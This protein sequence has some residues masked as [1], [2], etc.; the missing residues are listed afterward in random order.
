M[1]KYIVT[2]IAEE[3]QGLLELIAAGKA[4]AKKLAHV[5]ILLKADA[6]PEGPAW[7]DEQIAQARQR[8][9][10]HGLEAALVAS[11]STGRAESGSS[12][13]GPRRDLSP[14]PARR[15]R[16]AATS[17]RC[18]SWPTSSSSC[19]S[20]T[21][22]PTRPCAGRSKKRAEARAEGTMVPAAG[23][24][25]RVRGSD[26]GCPGRLPPAL[27]PQAG[28]G[29]SRRGEQAT[30]RRGGRAGVGGAGAAGAD[31]LRV[32]PQWDG[33]PV[34]GLRAAGRLAARGGDRAADG[35]GLRRGGAVA[36]RGGASRRGEGR[37]GDGQPEH[38]QA[39]IA[40][41]GVRAGSGAADRRAI[42][43]PS[44]AEARQLA[45]H[46]G[47]RAERPDPAVSGP[48]DRHAGG[49][50]E[51]GRRLGG[52][53]ERAGRGDP[54]AVHHGRRPHQAPTALPNNSIVVDY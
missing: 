38:A 1:K 50:A 34:H 21:R 44:H 45:E 25:R 5:R 47:D 39:G 35:G 41:R 6:A 7:N 18:S 17:G 42:G 33:E 20:W 16:R 30:Q 9:V 8:F 19:R 36:G 52:F 40:V 4:A 43:D 46:G 15:R 3:S 12:T 48:A 13:A 10:K 23:G 22:S 28:A 2:L 37:A 24:E 26:G 49:V 53:E 29:L 11:P 54:V 32:H 14:W 51:R 27:R 31:R